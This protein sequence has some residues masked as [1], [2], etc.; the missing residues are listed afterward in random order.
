MRRT[1]RK[2]SPVGQIFRIAVLLVAAG[3]LLY[4]YYGPKKR[5]P[6]PTASAAPVP[7]TSTTPVP[8][9][10]ASKTVGALSV[11]EVGL[12]RVE[13]N[14]T[15]QLVVH[16]GFQLSFN[17]DWHLPNWVAYFLTPSR[18]EGQEPRAGHFESDPAVEPF[19]ADND[20][21]RNSGYDRGHM[22]P[23]ADMK[24]N[25]KAMHESFYFS[26]ICP[27][28]RNLNRGDWQELE[29]QVRRWAAKSDTLFIVCGPFLRKTPKTIGA[30]DVAVP[31][32]F[33]KVILRK[34][35]DRLEGAGF[36][37]ENKA[38][39]RPLRTYAVSIDSI[40]TL[41]HIDFFYR[42]PKEVQAKL[43]SRTEL[44]DWAN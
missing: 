31:E 34:R 26:N 29:Q 17:P 10:T 32:G 41:T 5:E 40:E 13:D 37:F 42:L 21:Y 25:D 1:P 14:R 22:A 43:E 23:A 39:S 18:A 20:D 27:Q 9:T 11:G 4:H 6:V 15:E 7:A 44:A 19:S 28:N 2:L 38:G 36:L 12:P 24:W 3:V 35:K 30:H 16:H 33:Y 8:V